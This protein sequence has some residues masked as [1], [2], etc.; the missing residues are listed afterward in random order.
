M[1]SPLAQRQGTR[2]LRYLT[3]IIL[4]STF[5][6]IFP[7]AGQKFTDECS[8]QSTDEGFHA[9]IHL[10]STTVYA[11]FLDFDHTGVGYV[12][13]NVTIDRWGAA[14]STT[15]N[16]ETYILKCT[17]KAEPET[18]NFRRSI[19]DVIEFRLRVEIP[20]E[21][22]AKV[23]FFGNLTGMAELSPESRSFNLNSIPFTAKME[24]HHN[25]QVEDSSL[26]TYL[27]PGDSI[28]MENV[29][30]NSGNGDENFLL[31]LVGGEALSESGIVV[32]LDR[33]CYQVPGFRS[34]E[35]VIDIRS[36]KD[37][38]TGEYHLTVEITG[39]VTVDGK[40]VLNTKEVVI[41]ISIDESGTEKEEADFLVVIISGIVLG[42][43]VLV[44]LILMGRKIVLVVIRRRKGSDGSK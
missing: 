14:T 42:V 39:N 5:V 34:A 36:D 38:P 9:T 44:G 18:L 30:V 8:A 17:A 32:G 16:L 21:T 13:G 40:R 7:D 23:E 1:T 24:R 15:V 31:E 43:A 25:F 12:D 27:A 37:T 26:K 28:K 33:N 3:I 4:C 20:R 22:P 19:T 35:F 29:I 2:I 10:S 11:R 41:D 6:L